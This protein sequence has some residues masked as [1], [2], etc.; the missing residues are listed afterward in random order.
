MAAS[1]P[2]GGAGGARCPMW[3][4]ERSPR[5]LFLTSC[6]FRGLSGSSRHLR[7]VN[8][9]TAVTPSGTDQL[10]RGRAVW[11][12]RGKCSMR[13]EDEQREENPARAIAG[14]AASHRRASCGFAPGP[15]KEDL[16]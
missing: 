3:S 9:A 7:S 12:A 14:A 13:A 2:R 8:D 1:H 11:H 10:S 15:W 4:W 6:H 16:G 5:K